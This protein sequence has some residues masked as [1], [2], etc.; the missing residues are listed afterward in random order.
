MT[1]PLH[2]FAGPLPA[3]WGKLSKLQG[4][5]LSGNALTGDLPPGWGALGNLQVGRV[6]QGWGC[7]QQHSRRRC[8]SG[9][10]PGATWLCS[11]ATQLGV[12]RCHLPPHHTHHRRRHTNHPSQALDIQGNALSGDIP[13]TWIGGMDAL[14]AISLA[15]N[16]KLCGA[17]SAANPWPAAQVGGRGGRTV[18]ACHSSHNRLRLRRSAMHACATA[19]RLQRWAG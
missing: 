5:D 4:L 10:Y 15:Q 16:P 3:E 6:A 12:H 11:G 7:R 19:G 18:L 2:S 1:P 8:R 13:A 14:G 17:G 9:T